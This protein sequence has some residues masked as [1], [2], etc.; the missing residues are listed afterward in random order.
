MKNLFLGIVSADLRITLTVILVFSDEPLKTP[1]TPDIG[2]L[3]V[4][5]IHEA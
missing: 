1:S 2:R 5:R 4:R 3:M